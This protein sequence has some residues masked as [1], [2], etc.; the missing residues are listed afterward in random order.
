M[1]VECL[2]DGNL[3]HEKEKSKLENLRPRDSSFADR[4]IDDLLPEEIDWRNM[5]RSYPM[6]VLTLAAVGGFFLARN[7]GMDLV[8][9]LSEYVADEVSERL[10][11]FRGES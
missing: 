11:G 3:R 7:K 5:V 2:Q 6:P 1:N 8:S 4:M 10:S 9:A